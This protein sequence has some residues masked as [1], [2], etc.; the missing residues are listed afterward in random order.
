M[1]V[2]LYGFAPP[3][4]SR[5]VLICTDI[6]ENRRRDKLVAEMGLSEEECERAGRVNAEKDMT[7]REN[8]FF[9]Y[10]Y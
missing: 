6:W 4:S 5:I 8:V 3:L 2:L 10:K 9:R 7:D 1:E